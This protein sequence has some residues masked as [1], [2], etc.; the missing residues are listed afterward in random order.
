LGGGGFC[1]A[2]QEI[3]DFKG[4]LHIPILPYLWVNPTIPVCIAHTESGRCQA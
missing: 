2:E 3:G 1:A 4:R